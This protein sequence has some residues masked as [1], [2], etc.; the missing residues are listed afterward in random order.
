M[1]NCREYIS[2]LYRNHLLLSS[3]LKTERQA[4]ALV[5]L[6]IAIQETERAFSEKEKEND[7]DI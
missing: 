3:G 2:D 6:T 1:P 4:E 5:K 7:S